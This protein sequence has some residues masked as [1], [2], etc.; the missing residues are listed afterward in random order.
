M[1]GRKFIDSLKMFYHVAN[2]GDARSLAIHP[3]STTHSQLT[4]EEQAQDRRHRRLRAAVG[5]HR[6]HRRHPRRSRSG[7]CGHLGFRS[8]AAAICPGYW[9]CNMR[10]R[11]M[12]VSGK[13]GKP[14]HEQMLSADTPQADMIR[15]GKPASATVGTSL[16]ASSR[17]G[18]VKRRPPRYQS[19]LQF[20]KTPPRLDW[21]KASP[22]PVGTSQAS[23]SLSAS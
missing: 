15:S 23:I 19:S 3:A 6:A 9:H 2:I 21:W 7:A 22:V 16:R 1:P 14:H 13:T 10:C 17:A 12:S 8:A 20:L 5:R 18:P 4:P 11:P